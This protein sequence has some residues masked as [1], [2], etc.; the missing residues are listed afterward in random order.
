V[1]EGLAP[2]VHH[3]GLLQRGEEIRGSSQRILGLLHQVVHEGL[4]ILSLGLQC[5]HGSVPHHR[6]DGPLHRPVE[7]V[8]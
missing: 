2:S 4:E 3:P 6:K 8:L 7:G 5:S 1:D